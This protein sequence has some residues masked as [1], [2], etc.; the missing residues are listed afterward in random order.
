VLAYTLIIAQT[1]GGVK[2]EKGGDGEQKDVGAFF[3]AVNYEEKQ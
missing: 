3:V 2:E 1:A